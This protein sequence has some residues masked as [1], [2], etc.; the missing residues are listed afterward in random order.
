MHDKSK[1][2]EKLLQLEKYFKNSI[3]MAIQDMV[4]WSALVVLLVDMA[5]NVAECQLLIKILLKELETMHKQKQIEKTPET[6]ENEE[7]LNEESIMVK[8]VSTSDIEEYKNYE[9]EIQETQAAMIPE[10]EDVEEFDKDEQITYDETQ[11]IEEFSEVAPIEYLIEEDKEENEELN[12]LEVYDLKDYYTFVGNSEDK[13]NETQ[14]KTYEPKEIKEYIKRKDQISIIDLENVKSRGICDKGKQM[15]VVCSICCKSFSTKWYLKLHGRIHSGEKP[16]ECKTCNMKFIHAH[17]LRRHERIHTGEKPFNCK[18]CNKAF[19][20][21]QYLKNHKRIHT[22]EVPSS[23]FKCKQCK[24]CFTQLS[25]LKIH[26]RLHTGEKPFKCSKCYKAFS[27]LALQK[28][29]ERIHSSERPFECK[30]CNGKFIHAHHLRRHERIHTG[31][32]PFK[33]KFCNKALSQSQDLKK[34]ERIH[35]GEVPYECL[36]CSK[37]FRYSSCLNKHNK[38]VHR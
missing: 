21:S 2:S 33:C 29:H 35:T 30:T 6:F 12:F 27:Q 14:N 10:E 34:H 1:D 37:R 31:E 11:M 20:Q 36:E 13:V 19:T 32:K 8:D 3:K 23:T 16:Y 5:P 38:I 15:K 4:S 25:S 24:E 28:Q 7:T 26:E 18:I 9:K 17:H 22:G